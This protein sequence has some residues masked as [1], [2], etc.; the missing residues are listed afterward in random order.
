MKTSELIYVPCAD[1][2]TRNYTIIITESGEVRRMTPVEK[3]QE[4]RKRNREKQQQKRQR[5]KEIV[6]TVLNGLISVIKDERSTPEQKLDAIEGM[7]VLMDGCEKLQKAIRIMTALRK[8][9]ET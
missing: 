5:E 2:A 1:H 9:G 7:M 3:A 6:E 8:K 4:T